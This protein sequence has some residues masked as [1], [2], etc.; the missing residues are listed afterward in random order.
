MEWPP[1]QSDNRYVEKITSCG[2]QNSQNGFKDIVKK[3]QINE[4]LIKSASKL[5]IK[6]S[7]HQQIS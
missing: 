2:L 3:Q 7:T 4:L 5:L 1:G 6:K